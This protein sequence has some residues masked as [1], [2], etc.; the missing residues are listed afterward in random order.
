[1]DTSSL[2]DLRKA[3]FDDLR[4]RGLL[5][6]TSS[7]DLPALLIEHDVT[8]YV[9]YD[10]TA[11][12]LHVGNLLPLVTQ[13]R[14]AKA[15]HHA[16][17]VV[18]GATGM[19]GDPSGKSQERQLLDEETLARNLAGQR[20]QIRRVFANGGV[21][22]PLVVNNADW[23]RSI[24]FIDFLRDV[25][26]HFSVNAMIAKDSVRSRLEEREQ[27]ISFTEF[28]YQLL[29]AYDFLWL[30]EHHG[31]L[32]QI[33]A[34]D[35]WGN[36]TG[37]I[38]LIRRKHAAAAYGFCHPLI[39]NSEGKKFGK[40]EQGN[41][42]LDSARSSPYQMFQFLLNADDREVGRL[43]RFLTFVPLE[44]ISRLEAS[45]LAA[46]Q[47]RE[48]QRVLAREIVGLVHGAEEARKAELAT[49]ALFGGKQD[50]GG[51]VAST[52]VAAE[53]AG[54]PASVVSRAELADP[55][56]SLAQLLSR[57]GVALCSSLSGARRDI[58]QGG[59]YLNEQRVIDEKRAVSAADLLEGGVLLLRKGKK[60]Y[61]IVRVG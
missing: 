13:L 34:T 57:P 33:G 42:W 14:L 37:G 52:I 30:H 27:G 1:M 21:A 2:I 56:L 25:G 16:I 35:Q 39:T 44:E 58:S 4:G 31:C 28:S 47:A 48:A 61:H 12:S 24:G 10:P 22:E 54:A 50:G 59:I 45:S 36:I 46:P 41:V 3:W 51:D 8:F 18:G 49:Q 17:V 19:I 5:E 7:P 38:D 23:F 55:G 43:L 53:A 40:S 11:D 32:L 60:S 20:A 29:Q 6:Q 9:G 15:G 26:K